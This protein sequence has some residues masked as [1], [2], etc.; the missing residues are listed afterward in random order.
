MTDD[1]PQLPTR[2]VVDYKFLVTVAALL[3]VIIATLAMLWTRERRDRLTAEKDLAVMYKR[4]A[5]IQQILSKMPLNATAAQPVQ[6]EDLP[7]QEV[8][9]GGQQRTAFVLGPSAG[10]RLGFKPGDVIVVSQ[11]PQTTPAATAPARQ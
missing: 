10:E 8:T 5:G 7:T 2:T 6:R 1:S 3:I 4:E 11:P 9:V